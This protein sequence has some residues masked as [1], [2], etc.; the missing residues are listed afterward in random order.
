MARTSE[1]KTADRLLTLYLVKE[2][3]QSH[4]LRSLSETKLQKLVFLS[5]KELIDNRIKA[6]NYRFIKL[7][8]PTFSPELRSDLT[9]LVKQRYLTAPWIGQTNRMRMILE[10][11]SEVLRRNRRILKMIDNVLS[12][13]ANIRT[14]TLVNMVNRLSW[15]VGRT[16]MRCIEDLKLGTP[17]LYPLKREK[18]HSVFRI[19]EDEL[20]DLE[21][22]LNPKITK[23][24]DK[25]FDEMR[26]GRLLPHEG[27]FGEL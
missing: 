17:L 7:L 14:N 27:V 13:W 1:E 2:C 5:E 25:A 10:D 12:T 21:I 9:H 16:K 15:R 4:R 18:A 22:C 26:R 3:Y 19:T 20:E 6:F 24:L 8:H 11:F 23:D